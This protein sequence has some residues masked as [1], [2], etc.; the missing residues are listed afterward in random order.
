[1]RA[2]FAHPG[3]ISVIKFTP[4]SQLLVTGGL[5]KAVRIWRV[6]D[7]HLLHEFNGIEGWIDGLDVSPDGRLVAASTTGGTVRLWSVED[8]ALV[9]SIETGADMVLEVRFSP[10]GTLLLTGGMD[11]SLHAFRTADGTLASTYIFVG[12][13]IRSLAYSPD[14][15]TLAVAGDDRRISLFQPGGS[16]MRIIDGIKNTGVS[17]LVFS[18]GGQ[19]LF[20]SF[21]DYTLRAYSNADGTLVKSWSFPF[22]VHSLALSPDGRLL[23]ISLEDGT[24]RFWGLK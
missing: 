1:M 16:T 7:G 8:G 3:G 11:G 9:R 10:D 20:A 24:V 12:P 21:W 2:E 17:D 22:A 19:V 18:S 6:S 5:D 14:K 15:S 4:D 23:A 13:F